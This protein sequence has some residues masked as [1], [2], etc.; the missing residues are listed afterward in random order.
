ME[1]VRPWS[2]TSNLTENMTAASSGQEFPSVA[3]S[4]LLDTINNAE[5]LWFRALAQR[6]SARSK[7]ECQASNYNI[8][9]IFHLKEIKYSNLELRR[10][11]KRL[12]I[13]FLILRVLC[14]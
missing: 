14:R 11:Y 2:S 3:I 9:Q 4:K 13:F 10:R 8:F 5:L 7:C 12:L 1:E 6:F